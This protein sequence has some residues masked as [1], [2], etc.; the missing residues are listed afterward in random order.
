MDIKIRIKAIS[1][2]PYHE[3]GRFVAEANKHLYWGTYEV[4][5]H[6]KPPRDTVAYLDATTGDAKLDKA[7]INKVE[8]SVRR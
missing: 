8:G 1:T 6:M 4:D 7:I 2:E 3:E 5:C